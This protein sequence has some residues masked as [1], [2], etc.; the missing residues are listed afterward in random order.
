MNNAGAYCNEFHSMIK[1]D[2]CLSPQLLVSAASSATLW[3]AMFET[4]RTPSNHPKRQNICIQGVVWW[5]TSSSK[6][7]TVS[8]SKAGEKVGI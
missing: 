6:P 4:V 1:S 7:I 3:T 8:K 2:V 5:A